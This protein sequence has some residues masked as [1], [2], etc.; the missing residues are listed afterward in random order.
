MSIMAQQCR[1]KEGHKAKQRWME[2]NRPM[3]QKVANIQ[4]A[5]VIL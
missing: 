1:M 4:V 3:G 5:V 2:C